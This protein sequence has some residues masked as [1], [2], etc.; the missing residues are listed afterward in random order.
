MPI[1]RKAGMKKNGWLNALRESE[2]CFPLLE[3][4]CTIYILKKLLFQI[5]AGAAHK[6]RK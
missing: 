4:V 2:K 5:Y 1:K 6:R 3:V